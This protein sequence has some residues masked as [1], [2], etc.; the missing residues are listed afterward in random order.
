MEHVDVGFGSGAVFEPPARVAG[1]DDIAVARQPVEHRG[2]H[3]GVAEA[4]M[5]PSFLTV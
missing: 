1:L 3:F 5:L 2:R 4:F